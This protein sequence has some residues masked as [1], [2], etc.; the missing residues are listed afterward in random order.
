MRYLIVI[1]GISLPAG[2]TVAEDKPGSKPAEKKDVRIELKFDDKKPVEKKNVDVEVIFDKKA[3]DAKGK[4][5]VIDGKEVKGEARIFEVVEDAKDEKGDKK[6]TE[7]K[8]VIR[9]VETD[10][11]KPKGDKLDELEAKLQSLLKEI[12]ALRGGKQP[13]AGTP[14][15]VYGKAETTTKQ[16][17]VLKPVEGAAKPV[18]GKRVIVVDKAETGK[19]ADAPS[20]YRVV[21]SRDKDG[22][23]SLTRATYT[24]PT[25]SAKALNDFLSSQVKATVLEVKVESDKITVTTTPEIQH[26]IAS[27][28]ALMQG[29]TAASPTKTGA[30]HFDWTPGK[31]AQGTYQFQVVPS[32]EGYF[33]IQGGEGSRYEAVP[34]KE[35][36]FYYK[37]VKPEEKK[38]EA[39]KTEKKPE[40]T[41]PGK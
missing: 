32:K 8:T 2:F 13:A 30:Y 18:E 24:L 23:V 21:T 15:K 11:D 33:K 19:K 28:I 22:V 14:L 1:M 29:K 41:K 9:K 36:Q 35:G 20:H 17:V 37:F 6:P 3:G 7:K 5:I 34:G 39:G 16:G 27:L 40:T 10:S 31:D 38:P 26:T 4:V 25:A 12:Q